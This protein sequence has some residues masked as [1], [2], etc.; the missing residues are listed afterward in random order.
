MNEETKPLVDSELHVVASNELEEQTSADLL[1]PDPEGDVQ[2]N[3]MFGEA[4]Y[5]NPPVYTF[6]VDG[7]APEE[8]TMQAH[9]KIWKGPTYPLSLPYEWTDKDG[10]FSILKESNE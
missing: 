2:L 6:P 5:F 7:S 10:S 3:S 1:V 9:G 8:V 4:M